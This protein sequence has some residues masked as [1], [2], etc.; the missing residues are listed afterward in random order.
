MKPSIH[1]A[2]FR[3]YSVILLGVSLL[4][5]DPLYAY[6]DPG[7]GSLALQ[8]FLGSIFAG[9]LLIKTFWQHLKR[10]ARKAFL[11]RDGTEK[12]GECQQG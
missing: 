6:V 11:H 5:P 2:N 7:T 1:S 9:V 8:A 3:R 10:F 4:N 12:S